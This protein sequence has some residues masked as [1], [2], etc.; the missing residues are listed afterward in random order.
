MATLL[1]SLLVSLGIESGQ[2]SS[3]LSAAQKEMRATQKKFEVIGGNMQKVGAALSVGITAPFAA[4]LSKAIPA[5]NESAQ[6][7]GQVNAALKSMGPVAGRTT[8]QLQDSATALMHLSTFDDDDILRKVTANL[9]TFGNVAG[10]QFDRAQ[11]A[12]VDLSTRMGGDLQASTILVGKALNDP[13]KGMGALRKVGIQLTDQQR[14]QVKAFVASG[15]AAGAQRIILGELER[16]FGGSAKAMRDATPGADLKNAWDDFQETVGG[17]AIKVLPPL[18]SGLAKVLDAF[19]N[20]SP[21]AQSFAIGTAAVAAGIGPVVAALGGLVTIVAPLLPSLLATGAGT[22]ALAAGLTATEAAAVPV[23]TALVPVAAAVAAVYLAY[24]NWDKIKPWIDGVVDRTSKAAIDIN[25]KLKTLEDAANSFD[26]RM[27]IPTKSQFLDSLG[28]KA[29]AQIDAINAKLAA[30]QKWANDADAGIARFVLNIGM[31]F[32]SGIRS[33]QAMYVGVK[34]WLADKLGATLD[35]VSGKAKSVGDAFFTLYD[36]VVGHSY[37][38]DMVDEIGQHVGRL[39]TNMVA[40]IAAATGKAAE[41]FNEFR[42]KVRGIL[43]DLFPEEATVRDLQDKLAAIDDAMAKK[44]INPATWAAARARLIE[45][46][47]AAQDDATNATAKSTSV[48]DVIPDI[49]G[50]PSALPTPDEIEK[51]GDVISKTWDKAKAAN[52][53]LVVSFAGLAR[54]VIGSLGSLASNV[55]SGD[56]LGALSSVLDIV[57]QIGGL[58]KGTSTP[59]IRTFSTGG[60]GALLGKARGGPVMPNTSYWV[61]ERGP[62]RLDTGS[63][64]GRIVPNNQLGGGSIASIVPSPYFDA[65]VDGRVVRGSMPIAQATMASGM[66]EAGRASSWRARQTLG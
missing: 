30:V 1:G 10:E 2:F 39:D 5:A 4:L 66:A 45:Q 15:N 24:Q 19:N 50:R 48:T 51:T 36:R 54:D 65:V 14:D 22:R 47:Y 55:K 41:S 28:P 25:A 34:T 7:L 64:G 26:T 43:D 16:Q 29:Q 12:A 44:L 61:G 49:G 59:A 8:E 32:S 63:L 33:A 6:A 27:G 52:D 31:H 62:E 58:I 9:L 3:G 11:K 17:F 23:I 38:P 20:L 18:T 13:I 60:G 35:W 37:I 56:W 40:P 21:T 53:N 46:L 42:G 57:G